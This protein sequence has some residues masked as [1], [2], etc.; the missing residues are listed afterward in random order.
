MRKRLHAFNDC[1]M[2]RFSH[3]FNDCGMEILHVLMTMRRRDF[4]TSLMSVR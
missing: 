2:N 3:A 1:E 4:Y